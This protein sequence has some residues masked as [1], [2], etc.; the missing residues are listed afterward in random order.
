MCA[1]AASSLGGCYGSGLYGNDEFERYVQ[2]ADVVTLSA[3]DAKEVNART[4]MLTPWPPY[5]ADR[6]IPMN[7]VRAAK[8]IEC[9]QAGSAAQKPI[10]TST[11][12][13]GMTPSGPAS[14][15]QSQTSYRC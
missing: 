11:T 5:V 13:T 7:G 2:R 14:Q 8:A 6:R 3:G 15:T 10:T 4:H 1:V 12:E 9:Y